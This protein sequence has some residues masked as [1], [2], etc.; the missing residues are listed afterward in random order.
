MNFRANTTA[1]Y[2]EYLFARRAR[3]RRA[4]S[5]RRSGHAVRPQALPIPSKRRILQF[6]AILCLDFGIMNPAVRLTPDSSRFSRSDVI[7][8]LQQRRA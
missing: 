2:S 3:A 7:I 6:T 8:A 5:K 1:N 4:T